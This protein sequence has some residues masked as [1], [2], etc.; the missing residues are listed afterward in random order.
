MEEQNAF[1]DFEEGGRV[2]KKGLSA[3][4]AALLCVALLLS[5]APAYALTVHAAGGT[6][7][8]SSD[9]MRGISDDAL[10]SD[11]S[12]PGTHDSGSRI[13]DRFTSTW[14]QCQSLSI[15]EQLSV[16]VRYLDM[17]LEYD[18]SVSGSVRVV[19]SS[20]NCWS[21]NNSPLDLDMVLSACYSF[22]TDHPTETILLSVKEDDGDNAS[23]LASEIVKKINADPTYWYTGTAVPKLKNVR[24][25]IVLVKRISQIP[26][27]LNLNWGDQGSDGGSTVISSYLEVQDR[28]NMGTAKKWENAAKPMLDK[29]K[30]AGQFFINFLSTTGAGISGVVACSGD[31]NGY[32]SAYEMKNNK[33]Y[34]IIAFDYITEELAR[35]V[36]QCNDLVAKIQA[37]PMAGQYYYRVN[38]NTTSLVGDGWT[39]VSLKLYYKSNNGTGTEASVLLFENDSGETNGYQYVC[40]HGNWDFSG[41]LDGF[42]TKLEFIYDFGN[43]T[44]HLTTSYRLYVGR[45]AGSALTLTAS[46][47]FDAW[48]DANTPCRG[49]DYY[50]SASNTYPKASAVHFDD[51]S[52]VSLQAPKADGAAAA[53]TVSAHVFDQYGVAWYKAPTSYGLKNTYEGVSVSD[54]TLRVHYSANNYPDKIS[55]YIYSY[56]NENGVSLSTGD[57]KPLVVR[58]NPIDYR[59]LNYD[60]TVLLSSNDWAGSV[61]A[62]TGDTPVRPADAVYHYAFAGWSPKTGLSVT[63]NTYTAQFI[64]EAHHFYETELPPA[65]AP[66]CT[67][68]VCDICGY[69]YITRL[70]SSALLAVLE[71]A[72]AL[73]KAD[74]IP[75]SYSRLQAVCSSYAELLGTYVSQREI[76]GATAAI[77]SAISELEPNIYLTVKGVNGSVTVTYTNKRGGAGLYS[78]P[79]GTEVTLTAAAK[80]GYV[81]DGWY[82]T[83]AKRV[84]S[85]EETYTFKITSN[86]S[87]EARYIPSSCVSLTFSNDSGQ[88]KAQIDKTPE[89]WKQITTLADLLPEVP[90]KLGFVNG[91]W[92]YDESDVLARLRSGEDVTI[93]PEY[94]A[95]DYAPPAVPEPE[96]GRPALAL[97][98]QLDAAHQVGAFTMALGVPEHCRIEAIGVAFYYKPAKSFNPADI[99]VTINNKMLTSKFEV[100]DSGG[101]YT[102]DVT[103]FSSA[104]NW[105]VRGYVSYYDDT[106]KLRTAYTNQINI[107]N[108]VQVG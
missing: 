16:G 85:M 48:A 25:K 3:L 83:V 41:V 60:G 49:T 11:I 10:I 19:H 69:I 34:G 32:L 91:R 102:V 39:R 57:E 1:L 66:G 31:M 52:A 106:G 86:T 22:L 23:A 89:A 95:G 33:C 61:P 44:R 93:F 59:F 43:G 50:E 35:K 97:Y 84:F 51:T 38:M 74:Y 4:C 47:D 82:E 45:D 12:M 2:M 108:R 96:N 63:Q 53:V 88:I 67:E 105:A 15:G 68:Y 30:P 65:E 100:S 77:L 46:Y 26:F 24:K 107:V 98:Y 87:F 103:K 9:W 79:F 62:Y 64:A 28:Y 58:T 73:P 40:N 101:I 36:Y 13:V 8:T 17:R 99:V 5:T 94:D 6:G 54:G 75:E 76:D 20:V 14:A 42:P 71:Y 29:T 81:F 18:T 90:Y 92:V 21:G 37:D 7:L 70:D 56:Y 27:G 104:Y 80:E 72:A 78:V 55:T